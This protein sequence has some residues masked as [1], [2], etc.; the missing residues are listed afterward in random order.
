MRIDLD[1]V[2]TR[3][4]NTGR[5]SI[6][7]IPAAATSRT[8][9]AAARRRDRG[10]PG[11]GDGPV[12]V[13]DGGAH[14]ADTTIRRPMDDAAIAYDEHGLVPCVIQDWRDGEVLTLRVHER[15]GARRARGAPASCTCGAARAASCGTRARRP[16][17]PRRCARSAT[18]A[19]ATR[20]SRSSSPAGPACHTGERTCFHRGELEPPAP[21]EVAARRWSG[22]SPP[23]RPARPR[24]PTPRALLADPPFVGEKVE[25]EAEE[26][27]RA[28]REETRR[29]RGR[30][31]R[32]RALPPRRPAAL[33]RPRARATPRRCCVAVAAESELRLGVRPALDEVRALAA[34]HNLVP[35][36]QTF[37]EDCETPVSA[38]LKLRGAG[39][40]F[41]LESAEQGQRVGRWSFI[42]YRPRDVAALEPRRRR[43]P[44]RARRRRGRAPPPGAA[45]RPAAVRG[46]RGRLLRLRLRARRRAARPRPTRTPIGLPDLALML[47]DALVAFDHLK[48]TVTILANAY[49]E[50]E[51]VEAGYERALRRHRR[52]ARAARRARCRGSPAPPA[53][54]REFEPN[55]PREAFEAMVA[56]I[57]EYV[58]AGDAFQVVPSQRWSA[59][60]DVDPFSIYRGLRA[61]NPSPYMYFLDFED[62]QIVGASPEPLVTVTGG[63]ATTRP[64][65]G[66]RPRGGDAER[67]RGDR[68]R[69]CS[70][71]RRSARST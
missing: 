16:A 19:T 41:L 64:I 65:A 46:R 3:Q 12:G 18:T 24:A 21:H 7:F 53:P 15:R 14:G 27:A 62:F 22:R 69:S 58:H 11:L 36:R 38:F 52:G 20:C 39:P 8:L 34:E 71:T 50:E 70:P 6:G 10:A 56:R 2:P 43:R 35:V 40:A 28:A 31:G 29:A 55:M 51:G 45:A 25:E 9:G 37:L 42:G 48:H 23:A 61:I 4:K 67:G 17:T 33:P 60:V 59:E 54:S 5:T 47:T 26:V 44:V 49:V 1:K 68:R 63:R 13:E 32:R 66:T 57:V 30:G